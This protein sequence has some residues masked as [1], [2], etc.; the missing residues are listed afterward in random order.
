MKKHYRNQELIDRVR[1]RILEIRKAKHITQEKL[2]EETGFDIKQIGRIE[3]GET[4]P[5]ISTIDAIAKALKVEIKDL[6]DF[7]KK[8]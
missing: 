8:D 3:R 7:Q 5:T 4:N 1:A 2:V 6:F